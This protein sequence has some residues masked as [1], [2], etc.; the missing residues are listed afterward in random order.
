MIKRRKLK[1]ETVRRG[2]E[3]R[4]R[5]RKGIERGRSEK[6]SRKREKGITLSGYRMFQLLR[7]INSDRFPLRFPLPHPLSPPTFLQ[8]LAF[9]YGV[10]T[11]PSSRAN[12]PL[13]VIVKRKI[14]FGFV[15][16]FR[17]TFFF[18]FSPSPHFVFSILFIVA[19][20]IFF[21][22]RPTHD[23][24]Y[25]YFSC[26]FVSL[27]LSLFLNFTLFSSHLVSFNFSAIQIFRKSSDSILLIPFSSLFLPSRFSFYFCILRILC[28][29]LSS[30]SPHFIF[31][32]SSFSIFFPLLP[33]LFTVPRFSHLLSFFILLPTQ[34][35]S[36]KETRLPVT[37]LSL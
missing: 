12:H 35:L 27:F 22:S 16:S 36:D 17:Y 13:S 25:R 31:L 24:L 15:L 2:R 10:P 7:K 5:E 37:I 4:E 30:R 20:F 1:T 23:I 21:F 8:Q 26:P 33:L 9:S 32:L 18:L 14:N 3:R 29:S 11:I 19:V 6:E 28:V 34:V